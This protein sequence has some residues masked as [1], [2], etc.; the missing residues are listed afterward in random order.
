MALDQE[1]QSPSVFR[2]E[3]SIDTF[4]E[5]HCVGRDMVRGI[6]DESRS[7][8][9]PAVLL[10]TPTGLQSA[11]GQRHEPDQKG[12]CSRARRLRRAVPLDAMQLSVMGGGG[13]HPMLTLGAAPGK[14]RWGRAFLCVVRPRAAGPWRRFHSDCR[15]L[16]P[17]IAMAQHDH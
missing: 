7:G 4:T 16:T 5:L 17:Q 9:Y 8:G 10:Q 13:V 6:A 3:F 15:G 12:C 11:E 2:I 1:R 14:Q